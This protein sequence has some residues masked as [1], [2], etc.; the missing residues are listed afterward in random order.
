MS[1][2]GIE[3][4]KDR[5]FPDVGNIREYFWEH[6]YLDIHTEI[7]DT[8]KEINA[9]MIDHDDLGQL[10]KLIEFNTLSEILQHIGIVDHSES[11][12]AISSNFSFHKETIYDIDSSDYVLISTTLKSGR[13]LFMKSSTKQ[14]EEPEKRENEVTEIPKLQGDEK[15][16]RFIPET[17]LHFIFFQDWLAY[18]KTLE[19]YKHQQGRNNVAV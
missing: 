6:P 7:M 14:V 13:I 1:Y 17:K 5:M 8:K 3:K 19:K 18:Q 4:R 12:D 15:E 9:L 11:I 16:P 10:C 2:Q